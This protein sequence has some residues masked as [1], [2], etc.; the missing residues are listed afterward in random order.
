[1]MDST[2]KKQH[3]TSMTDQTEQLFVSYFMR[4]LQNKLRRQLHCPEHI[5]DVQQET[6]LRAWAAVRAEG[7]IRQPE[8]FGAFVSSVNNNIL[9]ERGQA[10]ERDDK[11]LLT[12]ERHVKQ[13]AKI[14]PPRV[15]QFSLLLIPKRN[16]EHLV[17]D[18][19]EEF[20]TV[21]LPQHGRLLARC[22]YC[23]QVMLAMGFYLW[24][25]IKKIL[26]LSILYKLI[27]R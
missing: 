9:R 18:L 11:Q 1:M 23:E 12:Q 25:T 14:D 3:L 20:R 19:E 22:W 17:G 2:K 4:V 26:G 10:R 16:R 21:V 13:K 15:A 7:G 5:K 6:L 8:R 24:P 27:G